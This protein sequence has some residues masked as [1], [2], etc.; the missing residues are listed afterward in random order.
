MNRRAAP[1]TSNYE[2]DTVVLHP[3]EAKA[4]VGN[5]KGLVSVNHQSRRMEK[6]NWSTAYST[7]EGI[8]AVTV[9]SA[10]CNL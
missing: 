9:D 1:L 8:S 3:R 6:M 4:A 2:R 7:V 5:E 10:S